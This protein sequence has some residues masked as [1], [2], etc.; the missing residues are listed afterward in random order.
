MKK[1]QKALQLF[2]LLSV[3]AVI[4]HGLAEI[5]TAWLGTGAVASVAIGVALPA[6]SLLISWAAGRT[7][8]DARDRVAAIV[9]HEVQR[10]DTDES[11]TELAGTLWPTA[12]D[13][14]REECTRLAAPDLFEAA[15]RSGETRTDA[16]RRLFR[17]AYTPATGRHRR[18]AMEQTQEFD[19][20]ELLDDTEPTLFTH[21]QLFG[22][23]V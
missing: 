6:W 18:S 1:I 21:D 14:P 9:A 22:R 7:I 19:V 16:K 4:V 3:F 2:A 15:R 10:K 20:T 8:R 11:V 13:V 17:D 12:A 5:A 23:G